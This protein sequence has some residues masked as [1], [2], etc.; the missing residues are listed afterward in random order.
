MSQLDADDLWEPDYLAAVLPCFEEPVVGLVYTDARI[1]YRDGRLEPY[2]TSHMDHPIDTFPD[3]A[4][5]NPAAAVTVTARTGA[6]RAVGGYASWLRVSEDY[7][8]Y[9]K[10][11]A[12]GW[13]FAY[14]DRPLARYRWP[15]EHG[16]TSSNRRRLHAA[17]L[18][19]FTAVKLRHP[20]LPGPGKRAL[21]LAVTFPR[22]VAWEMVRSRRSS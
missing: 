16:G 6:V 13:R 18:K 2:L 10:L 14:V 9:L 15:D 22:T 1:L 5:V 17:N 7:H 12:A 19:L 20:R 21:Q 11:A 3:I 4:W 8:L